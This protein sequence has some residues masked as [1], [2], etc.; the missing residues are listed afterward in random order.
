M[1][2]KIKQFFKTFFYQ[3]GV[4]LLVVSMS[5]FV[6]AAWNSKVSSNDTLTAAKWN[7]LIKRMEGMENHIISLESDIKRLENQIMWLRF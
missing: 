3:V 7:N 4:F 6:F 5:S 1:K 2:T